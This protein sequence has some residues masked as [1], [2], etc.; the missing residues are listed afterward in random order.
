[1]ADA[2]RPTLP[3]P[4]ENLLPPALRRAFMTDA[5]VNAAFHRAASANVTR[6]QALIDAVLL[7]S[8]DR[9]RLM[10]EL[11]RVLDEQQPPIVLRDPCPSVLA[12][13]GTRG[14][15]DAGPCRICGLPW[16]C[17]DEV[18]HTERD[19]F[20][21]FGSGHTYHGEPLGRRFVRFH[22][23]GLDARAKMIAAFGLAWSHQYATAEEAGV[24]KFGLVEL[25]GTTA[26]VVHVLHFGGA[27]CGKV[28]TPNQWE[29]G[30]KWVALLNDDHGP[31]SAATCEGCL[32]SA[33][34]RDPITGV[35]TREAAE[36][37]LRAPIAPSDLKPSLLAEGFKAASHWPPGEDRES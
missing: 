21:T 28:G 1:M 5:V 23:T 11:S 14:P 6:E 3:T 32:R 19:W 7:L 24:E 25:R 4:I 31:R 20:F 30:H 16:P 22:G 34:A 33:R 29:P 9:Q 15:A 26:D 35:M 18:K 27:L 37:A 36:A 17:P 12:D 8:E 13:A 10:V 2:D